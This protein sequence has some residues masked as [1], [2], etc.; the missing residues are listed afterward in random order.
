MSRRITFKVDSIF[1]KARMKE[2]GFSYQ[3]IEK[4]SEGMIT[5][6]SLKHFLNKGTTTDEETIDM[7]ANLLNCSKLELVDK[8][9][10]LSMNLSF[11]INNLVDMLYQSNHEDINQNYSKIINAFRSKLDLKTILNRA[12]HLFIIL[13]S[14]DY[15]FD[16]TAFVK[17]YNIIADN[18]I[19]DNCICNTY[20]TGI[21]D[22]VA[23]S[24]YSK[25]TAASGEYNTQQLLLMFL[26]VFILFDAI[27]MQESV[28]SVAQLVPERKTQKA[29]SYLELTY[30][31][32]KMRDTLIEMIIYKGG[33]FDNPEVVIDNEVD[34]NIIE[35]IALMLAACEKCYQHIN[36]D[37][38]DSEYVNRAALSAILR[39]LEKTFYNLEIELPEENILME[40]CNMNT[41][42]FGIH[43]N[44]LKMIFNSLNP[45]RKRR[46][47]E[48][49]AFALGYCS[50]KLEFI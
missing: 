30:R 23:Q 31:C 12:H 2:Q 36:G 24:L 1:I 22:T 45:P 35:T 46:D 44:K 50:A 40:Y 33:Q 15:I 5:E 39:R 7:L 38:V 34:D 26:Y 43:Y 13:L 6:I 16:K 19:H 3:D 49:E 32:E 10:I 37:F 20:T 27:F 8:K 47:K 9:S 17:A 41:T 18:Y 21:Q 25:I 28:A 29:D 42:R 48:Q 14:K 11:E 4:A